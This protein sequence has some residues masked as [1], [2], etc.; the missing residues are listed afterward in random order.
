MADDVKEEARALLEDRPDKELRQIAL[1]FVEGRLV[2]D[3]DLDRR[4]ML[5]EAV[6]L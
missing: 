1:D 4:G 3:R 5:I 2:T 6:F